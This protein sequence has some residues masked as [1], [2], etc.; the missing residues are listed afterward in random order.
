M[1]KK[2]L[3][4]S[5]F[6]LIL[7]GCSKMNNDLEDNKI[8]SEPNVII[9]NYTQFFMT[10]LLFEKKLKMKTII[11][12]R[13]QLQV[14][15][16]FDESR[17][18]AI[19]IDNQFS[20][21]PQA[22][23]SEAKIIYEI[24]AEGSITRYMLI[25]DQTI[26]G[27]IGPVRSARPY[28]L[29]F[30]MEYDSLY[31]HAGGSVDA[32]GLI[33]SFKVNDLDG[34]K[35]GNDIFWRVNQKKI[36]HNLY[37][38]ANALL[39]DVDRLKYKTESDDFSE[40]KIYNKFVDLNSQIEVKGFQIIYKTPSAN[41]LNGYVVSYRYNE[42]KHIYERLINN[43][44]QQDEESDKSIEVGNIIIQKIKHHIIDS[45]GRRNLDMIGTGV[46]YYISNGKMTDMRWEKNSFNEATHYFVDDVEIIYNPGKI[47][48]QVVDNLNQF[49]LIEE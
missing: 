24:L 28:F 18:F 12:Q 17:P 23:L 14:M 13:N 15:N 6:L 5:I 44:V 35:A 40:L 47:V 10:D 8:D 11:E 27:D 48:I 34:L 29:S 49:E 37:T 42:L 36:P 31:V 39:K 20:A 43:V 9:V 26:K 33:K 30:A 25:T 1:K 2:L 45:E 41:D 16:M 19:M 22:G 32:L 21:R 7:S 3:V 38:S 4:M 46:G